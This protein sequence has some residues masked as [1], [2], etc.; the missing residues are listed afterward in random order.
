M[1]NKQSILRGYDSY[2]QLCITCHGPN[3]KG[4]PT[5]DGALIAPSLIGSA[6]VKG[7]KGTLSK[8]LL[9]GLIG[10]IEG[11]EYG[12]MMALKSNDDQWIADVLSY[13]RALNNEDG[14]HKR[15]VGNARKES[16]GREDYWTLEEL[17]A[18]EK[19]KK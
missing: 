1:G 14:V 9:N 10:P 16:E 19:E 6:R 8:I 12:I 15:V 7:D 3:L 4:V 5:E 11:K 17:E 13:V 18:L 2:K